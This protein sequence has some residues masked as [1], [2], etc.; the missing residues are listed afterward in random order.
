MIAI[1]LIAVESF[2]LY[3]VDAVLSLAGHSLTLVV[4]LI[5]FASKTA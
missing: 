3:L 4:Y 1:D 5:S 2:A